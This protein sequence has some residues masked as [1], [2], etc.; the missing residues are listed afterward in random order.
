PD[1]QPLKKMWILYDA[2]CGLCTWVRTWM[3]R[4]PWL[5]ELRFL[6]SGSDE[7]RQQFPEMP[8]GELA[9]IAN[10][11]EVWMGN[12]AWVI[13]LWALRDYREWAIRLSSPLLLQMARQGF[14]AVSRNRLALSRLLS[15]KSDQAV[16]Q[17]LRG[18]AVPKCEPAPSLPRQV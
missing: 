1:L 8:F 11:G 7:A 15:L 13:Y 16:E 6:A 10:T 9:V 5:I 18:I 4:Q 17:Q 2:G 14:A 3:T 12:H